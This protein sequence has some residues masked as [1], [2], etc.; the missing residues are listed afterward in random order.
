MSDGPSLTDI[1]RV[2]SLSVIK[3]VLAG[4]IGALTAPSLRQS[5]SSSNLLKDL[6]VVNKQIFIPCMIFSSCA[7]GITLQLLRQAFVIPLL[8]CGFMASGLLVGSLVPVLCRDRTATSL[9]ICAC[10]FTNVL[11]L[12]L[13]LI[14]SAVAGLPVLRDGLDD[15]AASTLSYVFLANTVISPL[16]WT[17]AP[18]IMARDK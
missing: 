7:Q 4:L 9:S 14:S 17:L 2:V 8:M 11:G 1:V 15:A 13:P 10:T 12:P 6:S 18:I 3:L 5:C 16:M